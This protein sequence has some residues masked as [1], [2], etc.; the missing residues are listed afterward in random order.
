MGQTFSVYSDAIDI[1]DTTNHSISYQHDINNN[2]NNSTNEYYDD[3]DLNRASSYEEYNNDNDDE[4]LAFW[5]DGLFDCFKYGVCHPTVVNSLCCPQL[6]MGQ[7]LTR[8]NM[9]WNGN[10]ISNNEQQQQ[11]YYN[12]NIYFSPS[13]KG[14][15]KQQLKTKSWWT[16]Q[17]AFT[18]LLII[19]SFYWITTTLL[20]PPKLFKQD[21]T[22]Y[23]IILIP[24]L[25]IPLNNSS[26]T[27]TTAT[28]TTSG[29]EPIGAR[30]IDLPDPSKKKD[31]KKKL[32][33]KDTKDNHNKKYEHTRKY[34]YHTCSW[35]F[36]VYTLIVMTRL[37]RAVRG[38]YSIPS[39]AAFDGLVEDICMSFWCGCCS[40]AQMA[41]QTCNYDDNN[42]T[43]T[44]SVDV[45][46]Y[47]T[48]TGLTINQQQYQ[49]RYLIEQQQQQQ[50]QQQQNSLYYDTV[51]T[52]KN[53][54][55]MHTNNNN[56][57]LLLNQQ[58]TTTGI[59][60]QRQSPDRNIGLLTNFGGIA[61]TTDASI[62][63]ASSSLSSKNFILN[64]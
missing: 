29:I 45:A 9:T 15:R 64:V 62:I 2:N 47:C 22:P 30:P 42:S 41:R 5:K 6:L 61:T 43:T 7:I 50:H 63:S 24:S 12:D 31:K 21:T 3:N 37:R 34:L 49:N 39:R 38:R 56:N 23:D 35:I 59:R 32:K 54:G 13:D 4:Y 51:G 17:T 44:S 52:H 46:T 11:N 14:K 40:V 26:A 33:D 27:S 53:I 18:Q 48:A 25:M 10:A 58:H 36:G 60:Q 1:E 8:M 19:V 55:N 16:R 57:Q 20:D 28:T